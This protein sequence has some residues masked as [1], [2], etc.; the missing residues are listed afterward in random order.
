MQNILQ[1]P[2][3]IAMLIGF[4]I[5]ITA[6]IVSLQVHL[7]SVSASIIPVVVSEDHLDFNT[8]FP[9]EELQ[10][11]FIVSI[12]PEY[13]GDGITYKIIQKR[14]ELP[15][16]YI[17]DGEDPQMLGYYRNLCPYLTKVSNEGEGDME[18][19]AFLGSGDNSDTWV[20]YFE[21]PAIFGNVAQD[22]IGGVITTNGEY[23]CDVSI[24]IISE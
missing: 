20:I 15:P 21:V 4:S 23:G 12:S 16:D 14:K 1:K 8:V 2:K 5:V 7:T 3:T 22:H 10:G 19:S 6:A 9:G 18:T 17:G 24:D 11:N 13:E